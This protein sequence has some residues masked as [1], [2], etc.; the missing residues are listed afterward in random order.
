MTTQ[1]AVSTFAP[2]TPSNWFELAVLGKSIS[3]REAQRQM[4]L[5]NGPSAHGPSSST[6]GPA[7]S[8]F[9]LQKSAA[10][11]DTSQAP[12]ESAPAEGSKN[13]TSK[14]QQNVPPFLLAPSATAGLSGSDALRTE[15]LGPPPR[16]PNDNAYW[17]LDPAPLEVPLPVLQG[18]KKGTALSAKQKPVPTE[19]APDFTA[20][21][22][23]NG[24][25][26]FALY[27]TIKDGKQPKSR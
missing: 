24:K 5:P 26:P 8:Y 2:S 7:T 16:L 10:S 12:A 27:Q 1:E 22:S 6:G 3:L 25:M 21:D 11:P 9:S 20:P 17:P 18:K 13:E 23:I 19:L 4:S 15:V 14:G